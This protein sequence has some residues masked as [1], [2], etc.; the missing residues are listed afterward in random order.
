M[1]ETQES[2][3][4]TP[5]AYTLIELIAVVSIIVLLAA[6]TVPSLMPIFRR[7]ALEQGAMQMKAALLQARTSAIMQEGD[8]ISVMPINLRAQPPRWV[9]PTLIG[10]NVPT[11]NRR[12]R[13]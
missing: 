13:P 2:M 12:T 1:T 8:R 3:N 5:A 6:L 7:R 9:V 10:S 11:L 4:S